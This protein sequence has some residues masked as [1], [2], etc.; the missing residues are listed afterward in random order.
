MFYYYNTQCD[1]YEKIIVP[2]NLKEET[3][4]TQTNLNP[5]DKTIFTPLN[6]FLLCII[7]LLLII[8][9]VYQKIWLII[10]PLLLSIYLIYLNL[11][12]GNAY[13]KRGAK[14]YILPTS[15]S[16]VFYISPIGTKVKILKK[17]KNYTK[18]RLNNKIGWVKNEDLN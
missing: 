3:I 4:S 13:L 5:E 18:I 11:P 12:K 6:I 9:L 8:F 14:V 1:N 2:I 7:A 10:P 15:H 17:E 16:T